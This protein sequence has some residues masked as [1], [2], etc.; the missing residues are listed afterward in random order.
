MEQQALMQY[1]RARR[2]LLV[3]IA[4][5]DFARRHF[6]ENERVSANIARVPEAS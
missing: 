5:A 2:E 4:T 6:P 3:I 1:S